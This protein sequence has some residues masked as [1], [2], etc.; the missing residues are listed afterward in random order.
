MSGLESNFQKSQIYLAGANAGTENELLKTS[1]FE[2]G[3]L[4]MTYL[5]NV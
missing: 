5:R 3:L 2:K 4:S 1:A